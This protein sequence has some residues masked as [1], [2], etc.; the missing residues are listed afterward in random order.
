M[1]TKDYI[2]I[3]LLAGIVLLLL[4]FPGPGINKSEA[5]RIL[6]SIAYEHKMDSLMH[7]R[8]ESEEYIDALE[9]QFDSLTLALSR[10][11][12][13]RRHPRPRP[14]GNDSLR[15]AILREAGIVHRR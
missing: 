11:E 6:D 9:S 1:V 8:H 14:V 7:L 12:T 5:R 3:G 10:H 2:I 13:R 15:A 4:L